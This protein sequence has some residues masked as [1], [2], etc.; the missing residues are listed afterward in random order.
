MAE[1][2]HELVDD[3]R[4]CITVLR[5]KADLGTVIG[6]SRLKACH[7]LLRL[8]HSLEARLTVTAAACL[9]AVSSGVAARAPRFA[10]G[11]QS[12]VLWLKIPL[13]ALLG[14]PTYPLHRGLLVDQIFYLLTL[15]TH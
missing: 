15:S 14:A 11:L 1:L 5:P 7:L 12:A 10:L 4:G 8:H 3:A 6:G 13:V 2:A 9:A